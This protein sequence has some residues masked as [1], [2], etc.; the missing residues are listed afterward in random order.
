[1]ME[2]TKER[3]Q[4]I[5]EDGFLK[6]GEAKEMARQLLAGIEQEPVAYMYKDKLHADPRFS[7]HTRFGNW[8]QED[9]NE[10]EITEIPLYAAPP[11]PVAPDSSFP[12]LFNSA[13]ALLGVFYEFGPDEVAISE[14]VTNLEDALRDAA[15]L[16]GAEPVNGGL[17]LREGLAA[18]RNL[19]IAIDAEKIQA[20]RDALSE[21]VQEWI[22]CR[23]RMPEE[24]GRYWC[25]VEEQN[26]FGKSHYQWNCSWNGDRWWVESENSGRVT[27]WMPLPAAPQQ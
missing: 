2:L 19:G 3:L 27:H 15:M 11:A 25:Y 8:P 12:G 7:L 10:Y 9:I 24:I 26:D 17:T 22:P 21:S 18:I 16:Q 5:A 13:R 23:E 1:M 4:E 6:H 14:Y 20:E